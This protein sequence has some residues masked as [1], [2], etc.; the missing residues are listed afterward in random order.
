MGLGR[1]SSSCDA[2]GAKIVGDYLSC[3]SCVTGRIGRGSLGKG[4]KERDVFIFVG[5]EGCEEL[6]FGHSAEIVGE[7]GE[8]VFQCRRDLMMPCIISR[9]R[10]R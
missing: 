6:C 2:Q 1:D 10:N 5:S 7:G 4:L 8:N 9:L 3:E